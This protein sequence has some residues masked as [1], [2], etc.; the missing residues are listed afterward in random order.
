MDRFGRPVH[1]ALAEQV[2]IDRPRRQPAADAAVA[3]I[4][5]RFGEVEGGEV[6]FRA[7]SHDQRRLVATAR[8]G[9]QGRKAD[10]PAG[11]ARIPR[12]FGV[13]ARD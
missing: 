5:G 7:I 2:G 1:T 11:V 13:V 10:P 4:K 8:A 12:Q 3:Q 6:A 9:C